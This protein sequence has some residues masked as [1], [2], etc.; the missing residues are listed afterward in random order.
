MPVN[1]GR[2]TTAP[3]VYRPVNTI[4][5]TVQAKVHAGAPAAYIPTHPVIRPVIQRMPMRGFVGGVVQMTPATAS[6]RLRIE[7]FVDANSAR[8]PRHF[9]AQG[10][11]EYFID[12]VDDIGFA[13]A[14][15]ALQ[16]VLGPPVPF[17][18]TPVVVA[19]PKIPV[20]V[21][22]PV[23]LPA[24]Q[25]LPLNANSNGP[26]GSI[27]ITAPA[28]GG[29]KKFSVFT[30]ELGFKSAPPPPQQVVTTT[31]LYSGLS[32][33]ADA[34]ARVIEE[35]RVAYQSGSWLG[36]QRYKSATDGAQGRLHN[37]GHGATYS[38]AVLN[39]VGGWWSGRSNAYEYVPP[40]PKD[41]NNA[42]DVANFL[43]H[44]PIGQSFNFHGQKTGPKS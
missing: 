9:T 22:A 27:A 13:E 40:G 30:G 24:P 25:P 21:T 36:R 15:D 31:N 41:Y 32:A 44:H 4:A 23:T 6:E 38:L 39:E 18:P 17:T 34:L 14:W 35:E 26:V 20:P 8:I 42:H 43:F 12:L 28:S 16:G 29:K 1:D 10:L 19:A 5:R 7:Q 2:K 33:G 11:K 3:P 37:F